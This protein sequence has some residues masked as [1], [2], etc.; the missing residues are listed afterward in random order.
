MDWPRVAG[1]HPR[2]AEKVVEERLLGV[3][4][5]RRSAAFRREK[6]RRTPPQ[7]PLTSGG[8]GV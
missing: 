3:R 7:G 2:P 5:G 4:R 8:A 6:R 1:A